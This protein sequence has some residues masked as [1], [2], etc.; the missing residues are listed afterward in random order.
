MDKKIHTI[1][2]HII[3]SNLKKFS[4]LFEKD[5]NPK[6]HP[7]QTRKISVASFVEFQAL[8]VFPPEGIKGCRGPPHV[9]LRAAS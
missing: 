9:A 7:F 2:Q 8:R 1:P 4:S 5:K 3:E 6:M